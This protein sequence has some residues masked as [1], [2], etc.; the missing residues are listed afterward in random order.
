M[1]IKRVASYDIFDTVV[2]RTLINPTSVFLIVAQRLVG[3]G[4]DL[5]CD[6]ETF[7]KR[8]VHAEMSAR[9]SVSGGEVTLDQIIEQ[10]V[11]DL[12]LPV[13]LKNRIYLTEL[14]VERQCM[15]VIPGARKMVR[16]SRVISDKLIFVSDMYLPTEF[17]KEQLERFGL[18]ETSDELFVSAEIGLNK[19]SGEL[20]GYIASRHSPETFFCHH[21]DNNRSDIKSAR[22][23]GWQATLMKAGVPNK[24]ERLD[25][26]DGVPVSI[27]RLMGL[28]RLRRL[29]YVS[30]PETRR[31]MRVI[32]LE[33][34]GPLLAFYSWH[35]HLW[36]KENE[37]DLLCCMARDGQVI[38]IVMDRLSEL[39]VSLPPT[40][41]LPVS[42]H[43]VRIA[44]A[45]LDGNLPAWLFEESGEFSLRTIFDRLG[46]DIDDWYAWLK[47]R[48]WSQ[49]RTRRKLKGRDWKTIKQWLSEGELHDKFAEKS[50]QQY[51]YLVLMLDQLGFTSAKVPAL[52]DVGWRG[53]IQKQ[54]HRIC[55][56]SCEDIKISGYYIGYKNSMSAIDKSEYRYVLGEKVVFDPGVTLILEMLLS[57]DHGG[58]IGY[59]IEKDVV[60]AELASASNSA[61]LNNG[62]LDLRAGIDDFLDELSMYPEELAE[63]LGNLQKISSQ[64]LVS[65]VSNPS[66]LEAQ[67]IGDWPIGIDATHKN[68]ST[69]APKLTFASATQELMENSGHQKFWFQG[70]AKRCGVTTVVYFKFMYLLRK[71]VYEFVWSS[72]NK[73]R[74]ILLNRKENT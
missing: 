67:V 3:A 1:V 16:E 71:A 27:H 29:S 49:N 50:K 72:K 7:R 21:G 60:Y 64:N 45:S 10:L 36:S 8:R 34:V 32:G 28:L 40:L 22:K 74:R 42:R 53:T 24:Y 47:V 18:W 15:R 68:E 9:Q 63:V 14:D 48:G 51:Q 39:G 73:I 70:I 5:N 26:L 38:K 17:V 23:A 55:N 56:T 31:C 65:L 46:L 4:L 62:L 66:S 11:A 61:A 6:I 30:L 12:S 57:A 58:V 2:T 35:V 43:A 54:L 20:F 41:Y 37:T 25:S 13:E 44:E 52:C 33:V 19:F 59:S 69:I